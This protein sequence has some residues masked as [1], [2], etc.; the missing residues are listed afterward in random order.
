M[1]TGDH[2]ITAAAI[3]RE[4]E[5]E[6][7]GNVLNGAELDR[8]DIE[9]L[10]R[11]IEATAV[12]ARVSPEHKV[13]LVQALKTRGHVVAMTGDGVN[14]APALKNVDIDIDIAKGITGAEATKETAGM[15]LTDD[16]FASIVGAVRESR[17]IYENI[18]KFV[19]FQLSTS[20]GA[21]LIELG[22]PPLGPPMPFTA[23]HV[24]WIAFVM[25]GPPAVMLGPEPGRINIMSEAPRRADARIL[26][27]WRPGRFKQSK[28]SGEAAE[29]PASRRDH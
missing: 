10:S 11:H 23:I 19:R 22:A 12:F 25:D 20:V 7:E 15:V 14:D 3:A 26:T 5:L 2:A 9:A 4:L 24:L 17:T 18:V 13:E 6:L 21:I 8:I 29:R 27:L 28:R 16:N 1:I